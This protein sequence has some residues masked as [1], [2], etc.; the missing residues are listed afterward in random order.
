MCAASVWG[1]ITAH[2]ITTE[3]E[4]THLALRKAV[5]YCKRKVIRKNPKAF[6]IPYNRNFRIAGD[7]TTSGNE[8]GGVAGILDRLPELQRFILVLHTAGEY[9]PEQIASTFKFDMKTVGMALDAEKENIE[10]IAR[11]AGESGPSYEAVVEQ[12]RQEEKET[13]VP[14]A[15][16]A[17]AAA[18]IDGIASPVEKKKKKRMT[19]IGI[20]ALILCLCIA[21]GIWLAFRPSDTEDAGAGDSSASDTESTGD[22]SDSADTTYTPEALDAELTYY[23]DIE[24]AD[25][26]TVTVQ[27]DQAAA[28][29]TA[30]N[31]VS[32][33]QSGFYDGLTFHRIIEGF[34][35]QG[36]DPNGDGTGGSENTIVGEFTDNGYEND[37]SHTRGAVS[38]ARSGD[39][40]NSASSQFFIV[41]EDSTDLDGQYAVFGYVTEGMDVVDAVCE[42][43]EPVDSNGTI[44]AD[45]Q[46]VITS[47]TIRTE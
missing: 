26:G 28:P 38:M 33:A 5:D 24:I 4:F 39:D 21:G 10:R 11:R 43:A 1:G 14:A 8:S 12:I 37:L 45:A 41:Q 35:M 19:R 31:F 46:P 17:H 20:I 18:V 23:A 16:D 15:V 44:E 32:L 25:Y 3:G 27:L 13:A 6:R 34:V 40:Y 2:G 47:V 29:I 42:A 22:S 30:A 7:Q 9:L 36:G